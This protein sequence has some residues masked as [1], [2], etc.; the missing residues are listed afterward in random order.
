MSA[1]TIELLEQLKSLTILETSEL[2]KQIE[3][4]FG[5]DASPRPILPTIYIN[6]DETEPPE[7]VKT[8]FDV[9]LEEVPADKK[10]AILKAVRNITFLGL[11]EAKDLVESA[12]VV[13][14]E[15]IALADA[16]EIKQNLESVGAKVSLK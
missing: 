7:P 9:I 10:I 8:E 5:V 12:P 11:K 2:V 3:T 14:K 16:Q 6:K 15:A 1:K 13:V 4:T